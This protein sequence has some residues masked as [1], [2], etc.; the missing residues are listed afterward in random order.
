MML[1]DIEADPSEQRDLSKQNPDV[2]NRLKAIYDK[3]FAE[4]PEFKPPK[5]FKELRRIKGGDFS[6]DD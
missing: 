5:S 2:V 4:V 3:T 1:F 6:Y